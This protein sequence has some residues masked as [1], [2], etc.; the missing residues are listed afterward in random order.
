MASRRYNVISSTDYGPMIIN[1]FDAAVSFNLSIN[2]SWDKV[3][4]QVLQQ[5]ARALIRQRKRIVCVDVG[6]NLGALAVPLAR[7]LDEQGVVHA[8]EPQRLIYYML[9]GNVAIASLENVYCHRLAVSDRPGGPIELPVYRL[10]KIVNIGAYQLEKT[11]DTDFDGVTTGDN[12]T[13]DVVSLDSFGLERLDLLKID[14]EGMELKVLEGASRLIADYRPAILFEALK[15]HQDPLKQ[16]FWQRDY[17][18]YDY[19]HNTLAVPRGLFTFSDEIKEIA[20]ETA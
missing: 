15:G 11:E 1:R 18:L 2:G 5:L 17:R 10:D 3:A 7:S 4:V 20:Q 14:V 6:A 8:F 16:Y 9:C 19:L 13:V 12:E